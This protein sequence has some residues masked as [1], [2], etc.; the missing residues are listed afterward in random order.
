M[1][2]TLRC[3]KFNHYYIVIYINT[4]AILLKIHCHKLLVQN[5]SIP[6]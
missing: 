2:D 6:I 3:K 1:P 4:Y 5:M